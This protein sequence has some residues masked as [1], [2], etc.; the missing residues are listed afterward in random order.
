MLACI[1]W[2]QSEMCYCWVLD[3]SS[4]ECV[5]GEASRLCSASLRQFLQVLGVL[6]TEE[7]ASDEGD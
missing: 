1:T 7:P 4:L 3:L 2:L 6:P 5:F